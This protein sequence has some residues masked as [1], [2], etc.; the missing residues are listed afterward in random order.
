MQVNVDVKYDVSFL[1]RKHAIERCMFTIFLTVW[2]CWE[3]SS[4]MSPRGDVES[5]CKTD[6]KNS[7]VVNLRGPAGWQQTS[8]KRP[9]EISLEEWK[10]WALLEEG[11]SEITTETTHEFFF[12]VRIIYPGYIS[13][14]QLRAGRLVY[15]FHSRSEFSRL[16]HTRPFLRKLS[17]HL[18]LATAEEQSA[19]LVIRRMKSFFKKHTHKAIWLE[20]NFLP[21]IYG[22][23]WCSTTPKGA[24]C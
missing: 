19:K 11:G 17:R 14:L 3:G 1:F 12:G 10:K 8:H 7:N 9:P 13:L 23:T 20:W 22:A 6:V 21:D 18:T 2:R 5:T 16:T 4:T 24:R 15:E